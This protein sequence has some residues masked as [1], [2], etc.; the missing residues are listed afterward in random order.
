VVIRRD[1]DRL[2]EPTMTSDSERAEVLRSLTIETFAKRICDRFVLQLRPDA[3]LELE[4]IEANPLDARPGGRAPFS[5]LFRGPLAH[6]LPQWIY[7]LGHETLGRLEL[8]IV[9]IGPRDGGMVYEAI[10]T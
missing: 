10:F 7:P 8:F 5:I 6:V 9:P 4:L 3:A 2:I 1:W